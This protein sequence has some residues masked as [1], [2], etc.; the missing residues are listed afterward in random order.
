MTEVLRDTK[1]VDT[2]MR[3]LTAN[4]HTIGQVVG[5][6]SSLVGQAN[7]LTQTKAI[8]AAWASRVGKGYPAAACDMPSL[9]T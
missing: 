9:A 7:V 3:T 5:L 1:Q 2:I 4:V 6:L 8:D